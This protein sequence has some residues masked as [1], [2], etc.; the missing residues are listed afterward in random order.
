MDIN[1]LSI[2]FTIDREISYFRYL[3]SNSKSGFMWQFL[4]R[5]IL[6]NRIQILI[7][8]GLITVFM[9]Y[10]GSQIKMSYEMARMLPKE[11]SITIEYEEF[12]KQFGQDGSVIFVAIQDP[13]LFTL[14]HFND[15]YDLS[16]DVLKMNGVKEVISVARIYNLTRNDSLK[17]FDFLIYCT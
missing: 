10:K 3:F 8:I 17:K 6:R 7:F 1:T 4:V 13:D 9:G 5:F 14:E 11:H 15:W 2:K 16:Y 12:K